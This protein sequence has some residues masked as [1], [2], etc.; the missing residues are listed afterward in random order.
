MLFNNSVPECCNEDRREERSL[1]FQKKRPRFDAIRHPRD[2]CGIHYAL[3]FACLAFD[4]SVVLQFFHTQESTQEYVC[5]ERSFQ[6]PPI[7]P[8]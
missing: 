5:S 3:D 4:G 7:R 2:V 1:L 8:T 6:S